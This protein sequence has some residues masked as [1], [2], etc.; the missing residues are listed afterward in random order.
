[1]R[2]LD[3]LPIVERR[4]PDTSRVLPE[5]SFPDTLTP[6]SVH[7]IACG[8][9]SGNVQLLAD[10][11]PTIPDFGGVLGANL[12]WTI[13]VV[14]FALCLCFFFVQKYRSQQNQ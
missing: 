11:S 5:P 9:L 12:L 10:I 6:D 13:L 1:M 7:T 8:D 3:V 2:L 14:L 4:I